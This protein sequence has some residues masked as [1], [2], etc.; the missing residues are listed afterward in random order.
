MLRRNGKLSSGKRRGEALS[1]GNAFSQGTPKGLAFS[2]ASGSA[3]KASSSIRDA[4]NK[5]K[6]GS[7]SSSS[8]SKSSSSS[9]SGS[10][11]T[12]EKIDWIAI[13]LER[14]ESAI[15]KV[16]SVAESA[17]KSFA[18][19]FSSTGKEISKITKEINLQEKAY[20]RYN[21]E[22]D[23]VKLSASLKKKVD[24]GTID[25]EAYGSDTREAIEEYQ[26]WRNK[27]IEC[28]DAIDELHESLSELYQERFEMIQE[29]YNNKLDVYERK[30][31]A[32]SN[33]DYT[34][35]ASTNNS[36]NDSIIEARTQQVALYAKEIKDL[37]GALDEAVKKGDVEI[38]ST[39]WYEMSA[40]VD[41]VKQKLIDAYEDIAATYESSFN[42][43]KDAYD[44]QIGLL[45]DQLDTLSTSSAFT[46]SQNNNFDTQKIGI[47]SQQID[48]LNGK[49]KALTKERDEAVKSGAIQE[50]TNAWYKMQSA[51]DDVVKDINSAHSSIASTYKDIF[52]NLEG[53]Y[54]NF[55]GE[56]EH[57]TTMLNTAMD[58][59]SAKGYV[60][61]TK[62]YDAL[63]KVES[64]NIEAMTQELGELKSA[65]NDAMATGEI[66][67]YSDDW[68]NM[69][70]AID[71]VEESIAK[72]NLQ[73]V[74]Y[75]NSMREIEWSYFDMLQDEINEITSES[76]FLLKLLKN[77]ELYEETGQ[78]N[79]NGLASL[80]L[81]AQNYDVAMVQAD[82]YS[83]ALKELNAVIANDPYNTTLLNRRKELIKLQ[84]ESILAAES[85]KEAIKDLV[86]DGINKEL[87]S[88]SDLINNYKD[89]L[90]SVKD[91]YDYQKKVEDQTK[92][93]ATLRKQLSAYSNDDSEENR[94]RV[95]KIEVDL[96]NAEE[97]L[98]ETEYEHFIQDTEKLLDG[99][100]SDYEE[101]LNHRLD[102]IDGLMSDMISTTNSNA[103][104][105][106]KNI[107]NTAKSI[108][109]DLS[110]NITTIWTSADKAV[111]TYANG[112]NENLNGVN[113]A[114]ENV[115]TEVG[116]QI[117]HAD[118]AAAIETAAIISEAQLLNEDA[119]TIDAGIAVGT[120]L[121]CDSVN[122]NGDMIDD[123]LSNGVTSVVDGLSS[124]FGD[125]TSILN[126][127]LASIGDVS[128]D[129]SST[130]STS[131]T[132]TSTTS[133][134]TASTNTSTA[135]KSTTKST[136]KK[137]TTKKSTTPTTVSDSS[138]WVIIKGSY[139]D[140]LSGTAILKNM[141]NGAEVKASDIN[142]DTSKLKAWIDS[143]KAIEN[144][145]AIY[146]TGYDYSGSYSLNSGLVKSVNANAKLQNVSSAGTGT[147]FNISID[148]VEDY[149]DFVTQL[150]RDPQFQNMVQSMTTGAVSGVS[151]LSKYN[152]QW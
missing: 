152:Y 83:E 129:T 9:D 66:A 71:G 135:K 137:S 8:S 148:K 34:A 38:G 33:S 120:V 143:V 77:R 20:Q 98:A 82:K 44:N 112:I 4:Y 28:K 136:K 84:R 110:D 139:D 21:K 24:N 14:L 145:N 86:E 81:M 70:G 117:E 108:G 27:A 22:A 51:I 61:S 32:L 111:E 54:N 63:S 147:V 149:N 73:L 138:E 43:T 17:F 125:I 113:T 96:A 94:A 102:D 130:T 115:K 6:K 89:S 40:D 107:S 57:S 142:F 56:L 29:D 95:Q 59:A 150:Q 69:Q 124:G 50:G 132:S 126:S 13:A 123:T 118:T 64:K 88:L 37:Q 16:K 23:S 39:A 116:K 18:T 55:L 85:E 121:T 80:G 90:S 25:I 26:K 92:N 52:S 11:D 97:E 146:G 99:L 49:L 119:Q 114:I 104:K 127:I 78:L 87:S 105:I 46:T 101:M 151:G 2:T 42:N 76:D 62:Y 35:T 122:E 67:K 133:S 75:A 79:D 47:Y 3:S 144:A 134:T 36:R 7:S 93:I 91:L 45:Q 12:I 5:S 10:E 30:I 31:S 65:M 41:D 106:W 19:K 1:K 100:Y 103:D 109:Y 48:L 53:K 74:E 60:E 131:T 15:K 140:V 68:Y 58:V 72:A 128:D 141:S